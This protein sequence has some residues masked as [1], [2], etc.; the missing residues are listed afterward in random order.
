MLNGFTISGFRNFPD[1]PQTVGPLSRINIFIGTNNS[2][3]SNILRYVNKVVS[4]AI[5]PGRHRPIRIEGVDRPRSGKLADTFVW[6]FPFEPEKVVGPNSVWQPKWTAALE[7][8]GVLADRTLSIP[9]T[10]GEAS[11]GRMYSGA[12][13]TLPHPE[14]HEIQR[15]W[16]AVTGMTGGAF[17]G[18]WTD[19]LNRF[20]QSNQFDP[21]PHFIPAFRQITT[22][23][24][25]F[26]S[27]FS[28]DAGDRHLIEQLAD[29]AHPPYDQQEKKIEFEKLR[30]FIG[31]II[32]N[33]DVEIEIPNDRLTINV[34]SDENFLPI[35]ALGAGVHEVFMLASEIILN[36]SSA[37]LLEEP[38]VHLHP[39]LQRRLMKFICDETESQYFITT[40]SAS[41]IDTPGA[42][43]FGVRNE[44]GRAYIRPLITS[45][46]KFNACRE[47]GF[48]ASD[49]LQ[50]NCVIWVEGP[51]D[52]IYLK[53]WIYDADSDLIEGVDFTIMFYGGKLLSRLSVEDE[54]FM[55]YINLL[56][57]NRHPAILID[58][59]KA[60]G[61]SSL[62]ETKTRVLAEMNNINAFYWVT[63]GREIE[64]YY[65]YE[66]RRKAVLHVHPHSGEGVGGRGPYDKPISFMSGSPAKERVADKIGVA[67]YLIEN[68]EVDVR[69]ADH[70]AKM[71][72]LVSYIRLANA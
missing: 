62:R 60:S 52:R 10:L 47:L 67:N 27:E 12:P 44:E 7:A 30:R 46:E 23:L 26:Y 3:K 9:V 69:R 66:D 57:I 5:A 58:S 64:N 43:V 39:H 24:E 19:L 33:P 32:G 2:G 4:P 40:H 25:E 45:H 42:S 16:N 28:R 14:Q 17:R 11:Q 65:S 48:R 70:P 49:L 18:W 22:K 56:S 36:K 35:E 50:S 1:A 31:G 8:G 72:E 53:K 29:L 20:I 63:S 13:P 21:R 61:N 38:E 6:Q 15:A 55:D 68:C 41:I 54:S 51:S 71:S 37:I 34:K 59:D